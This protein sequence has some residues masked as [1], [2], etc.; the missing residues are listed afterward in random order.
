MTK[1]E[2]AEKKLLLT[3]VFVC[4]F[5]FPCLISLF[6]QSTPGLILFQGIERDGLPDIVLCQRLGAG[7][8]EGD[9]QII[10][11]QKAEMGGLLRLLAVERMV[12]GRQQHKKEIALVQVRRSH[13]KIV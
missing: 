1:Q 5:Q 9:K 2:L 12:K 4:L 6:D 8:G 13:I 10:G 7:R 3:P 11:H